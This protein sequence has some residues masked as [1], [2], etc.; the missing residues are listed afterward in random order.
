MQ[1]AAPARET[2]PAGNW[3]SSRPESPT[4][5]AILYQKHGVQPVRKRCS[6]GV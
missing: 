1:N 4:H 3:L 5:D 6:P 2:L